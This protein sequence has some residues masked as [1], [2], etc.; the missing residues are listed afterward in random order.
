M[1]LVVFW[2][3]SCYFHAFSYC[4]VSSLASNFQ[5][6]NL[7]KLNSQQMHPIS[8]VL[9]LG[10]TQPC[11]DVLEILQLTFKALNGQG[12]LI[13]EFCNPYSNLLRPKTSSSTFCLPSFIII[14]STMAICKVWETC[15]TIWANILESRRWSS[16]FLWDVERNIQDQLSLDFKVSKSL[17]HTKMKHC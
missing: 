6:F 3:S 17:Q 2:R 11:L 14:L 13:Q 12:I 8:L 5:F 10:P 4:K 15:V 7:A 9:N 16:N 1:V